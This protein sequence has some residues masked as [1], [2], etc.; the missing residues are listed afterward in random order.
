[1]TATVLTH[2]VIGGLI[3]AG[4]SKYGTGLVMG[5]Y[6]VDSTENDDWIILSEFE[7]IKFVMPMINTSGAITF[8]AATAATID[9]TTAN[10]LVLST[11]GSDTLQILVVG[12]P[13]IAN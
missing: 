6:E 12:T 1:M 9:S 5:F 4:A 3:G 8:A 7:A 2:S 10:K 11:G 13:A